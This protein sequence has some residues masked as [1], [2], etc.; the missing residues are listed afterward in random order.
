MDEKI[1]ELV[2]ES[3][4]EE[5]WMDRLIH[6]YYF[7]KDKQ[8]TLGEW[9]QGVLDGAYENDTGCPTEVYLAQYHAMSSYLACMELRAAIIGIS[10]QQN[11]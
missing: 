11:H 9:I 3:V 8:V 5:N 1:N 2:D 4:Q 10:N 7:V 6:E